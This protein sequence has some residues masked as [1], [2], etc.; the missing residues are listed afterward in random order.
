MLCLIRSLRGERLEQKSAIRWQSCFEYKTIHY[1]APQHDNKT[2]QNYIILAYHNLF[3]GPSFVDQQHIPLK[4][5]QI[6]HTAAGITGW[7]DKA[8]IQLNNHKYKE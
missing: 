4:I 1:I 5:S 7:K 8:E 6:D 3:Y 2:I